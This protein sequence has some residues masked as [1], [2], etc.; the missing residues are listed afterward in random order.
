MEKLLKFSLVLAIILLTFSSCQKQ[1][2]DENLKFKNL[3]YYVN[4][5]TY[6]SVKNGIYQNGQVYFKEMMIYFKDGNTRIVEGRMNLKEL[7][8]IPK[9]P[10]QVELENLS[11]NIKKD[12]IINF[13]KMMIEGYDVE[14]INKNKKEE[15]VVKAYKINIDLKENKIY[16][17]QNRGVW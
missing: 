11:I 5:E 7:T 13:K 14:I 17:L 16:T 8:I 15:K 10:L 3:T 2:K 12:P 6:F 4:N 1:I 9:P